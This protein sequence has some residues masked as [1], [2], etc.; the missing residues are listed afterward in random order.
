MFEWDIL[1]TFLSY[2]G[3]LKDKVDISTVDVVIAT[4]REERD[5]DVAAITLA[6]IFFRLCMYK[7]H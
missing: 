2:P 1:S 3:Q 7:C 4:R 5:F 6:S